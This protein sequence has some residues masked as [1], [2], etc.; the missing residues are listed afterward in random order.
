MGLF[1]D[2][3]AETQ[4]LEFEKRET[5][6]KAPFS[7][8]GG[9]SR[10]VKYIIPHLPMRKV[11]VDVFGGS[12]VITI[13]RP[14]SKLD[15]YNDRHSGVTDFYRCIRDKLLLDRLC[16][17]L[18]NTLHSREEFLANRDT[19]QD[20]KD[21]VERA[22]RW[23]AMVNYSFGSLGR[24]WGRSTNGDASLSGKIRGGIKNLPEIHD[25]FRNVQ[26][27][28]A[29]WSNILRDYDGVDTVFYLDPPYVDA[30]RGTYE[31]EMSIEQHK[32][33][34]DTIFKLKGFVAISG[35]PNPL[36]DKQPWDKVFHWEVQSTAKALA[37][38]EE[39]NKSHGDDNRGRATEKLW[40]KESVGHA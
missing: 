21:P 20:C 9:K 27:E 11:W 13:N 33:M 2:L 12:G 26:I 10:S 23:F 16:A 29:D 5:I 18:D 1:D 30:Y 15:V 39:N 19:W 7:Y 22:G 24:N 28:N 31:Y 6:I 14:K 3:D 8:P 4:Q 25:R 34:I 36:Y 37:F 35:Y 17:W 32:M 40:I 38:H